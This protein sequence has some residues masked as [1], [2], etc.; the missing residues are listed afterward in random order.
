MPNKFSKQSH[1]SNPHKP[2]KKFSTPPW[3]EKKDSVHSS[4]G[5]KKRPASAKMTY[6]EKRRSDAIKAAYEKQ[7]KP[8]SDPKGI[9]KPT[10]EKQ[11]RP[12][13]DRPAFGDK[14]KPV[15][16]D[17][18]RSAYDDRKKP[19]SYGSQKGKFSR[20]KLYIEYDGSRFSGWQKQPDAKTIQG[21]LLAAARDV[22]AETPVD[23][24]GSGRTD[25]G[26][27]ALCQVAHLDVNTMLAPEII[28]MKLNDNLPHDI[29]ILEVEKAHPNFHA[30]H[31][32]I[33]RSY[34]YQ[35]S[36]RRSAFGKNFSWWIKDKLNFKD[37]NEASALL[38]GMHNFESF[39]DEDPNEKSTR[40]LIENIQLEE[41]GALI[42]IR[43]TGSH[44]LWKMVRRIAG[45]LVEIGRGNKNRD[46][47]LFYL[48]NKSSEPA[49][50]TAPP[51]G[52]FLEGVYYKGDVQPEKITI[53]GFV[54]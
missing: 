52:L 9:N 30:R 1:S 42:L 7:E 19:G 31:D 46:D 25:S 36:R 37:M 33:A 39:S 48:E 50:Y 24:Q 13:S 44:F 47:L 16:G 3:K 8:A 17:R 29:H 15:Y 10:C 6:E 27:H 28:R 35:V 18:K 22:F 12:A 2:G 23:I 54:N 14:K 34:V 32:A 20:F 5:N 21:T 26:V 43:I 49:R 51:A 53:P 41:K 38:K 45:I 11:E 40:V 4:F